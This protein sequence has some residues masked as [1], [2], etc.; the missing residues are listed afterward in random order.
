M[1]TSSNISFY[2]Q[3]E[4]EKV[5]E[6]HNKYRNIHGSPPLKLNDKLS[7]KA[8]KIVSQMIN[9]SK[10]NLYDSSISIYQN[11]PLGENIYINKEQKSPK[12]IF[13]AWYNEN[14]KYKYK[15]DKFQK[16]AI[17]FTQIVWKNTKEVG[18]AFS[19]AK[20]ICCGVALYYPAG[21]IFD[22]FK[23]NVLEPEKK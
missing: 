14:I 15:S 13:Q 21:N 1:G 7:Q 16:D 5:L 19:K 17:H 8:E 10:H 9:D 12:E 6:F 23:A 3:K 20:K 2:D 22:Q 4:L 11:N 18:F